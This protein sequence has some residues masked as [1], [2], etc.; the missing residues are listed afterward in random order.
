[1][2]V[3]QQ[4]G[5]QYHTFAN[6][7]VSRT[8]GEERRGEKGGFEQKSINR[9]SA[10]RKRGNGFRRVL[11][12]GISVQERWRCAE[13]RVIKCGKESRKAPDE[14]DDLLESVRRERARGHQSSVTPSR[15]REDEGLSI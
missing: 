7:F 8:G 13:Q 5:K 6:V 3:M 2:Y 4:D 11:V 15:L 12:A 14:K 10:Y 9:T 1:M